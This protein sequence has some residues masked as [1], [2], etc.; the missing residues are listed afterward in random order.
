MWLI[1][2]EEKLEIKVPELNIR[3]NSLYA[4]LYI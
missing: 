3:C 1:G 2:N 4:E